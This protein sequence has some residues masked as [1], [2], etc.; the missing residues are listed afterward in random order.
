MLVDIGP[1]KNWIGPYQIAELLKYVGVSEDKCESIGDKLK[2]TWVDSLCSWIFSKRER[3][4]LVRIDD[5]DTWS[6]DHTLSYIILPMLKQLK[7]D[8]HGAP[9]V[10]NIDVPEGIRNRGK[11]EEED[12]D[13]LWSARWNYVLDRMIW[14][15]EQIMEDD[16][17]EQYYTGEPD[18]S[19]IT[20]AKSTFK[21]DHEGMEAHQKKIDTG[22]RLFG[23]YYQGLWD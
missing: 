12:N 20:G 13:E 2:D 7:K 11:E 14:S 5:Y 17:Q 6:M 16:W 22:L 23:K 18:I 8:T 15:F 4:V 19:G 21:V 9:V 10:E 1:Y 3:T